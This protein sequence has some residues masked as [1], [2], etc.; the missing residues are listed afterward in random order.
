MLQ[1]L[2]SCHLI[3]LFAAP[4]AEA[5]FLSL[6]LQL[7][8]QLIQQVVASDY[9]IRKRSVPR[10]QSLDYFARLCYGGTGFGHTLVVVHHYPL[11]C[12]CLCRRTSQLSKLAMH[13]PDTV[14]QDHRNK[15]SR[16]Q[17]CF[18]HHIPLAIRLLKFVTNLC[19][20]C[21]INSLSIC[22]HAY[23]TVPNLCYSYAMSDNQ[24]GKGE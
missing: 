4:E 12:Y 14:G 3:K 10:Y 18:T 21:T 23:I 20:N 17:T 5:G 8:A 19:H 16:Q 9:H 2:L 22:K 11:L 6:C 13:K 15:D 24:P 7:P 1:K